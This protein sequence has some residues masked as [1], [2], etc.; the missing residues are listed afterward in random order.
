MTRSLR[1][2]PRHGAG[3]G[4]RVRTATPDE[5]LCVAHLLGDRSLRCFV[6]SDLDGFPVGLL[7]EQ[8]DRARP[9]VALWTTAFNPLLRPGENHWMSGARAIQADALMKLRKWMAEVH[10]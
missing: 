10:T 5:R 2:R 9:D 4:F 7:F 6:V 3:H 8:R 1:R